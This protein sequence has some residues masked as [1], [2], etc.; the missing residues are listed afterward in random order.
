MKKIP[1]A[2]SII[3]LF[4]LILFGLF[5]IN[6][7][8]YTEDLDYQFESQASNKLS[9]ING[10]KRETIDLRLENH[11]QKM[12]LFSENIKSIDPGYTDNKFLESIENL[13]VPKL[14]LT[15]ITELEELSQFNVH[16]DLN[17]Q[18]YNQLNNLQGVISYGPGGIVLIYPYQVNDSSIDILY[19]T[20]SLE[21][22][23]NFM[24]IGNTEYNGTTYLI[25]EAG[26]VYAF[27]NSKVMKENLFD[28]LSQSLFKGSHSFH[29]FISNLSSGKSGITHYQMEN[30]DTYAYYSPTTMKGIYLL[31]TA[32]ST[33]L[34]RDSEAITAIAKRFMNTV[35]VIVFLLVIVVFLVLLV[36]TIK[37]NKNRDV[38]LLEKQRYQIALSHSKDTIWEYNI[39]K[40][41]LTKTEPYLGIFYGLPEVYDIRNT[42]VSS[43]IIHPEDKEIFLQFCDKLISKDPQ[44]QF[45]IRSK[46]QDEE[47]IWY[48]LSGTKLFDTEGKPISVIGQTTNIHEKK[49]EIELLRRKASQDTLTK[50]Y[51]R[52]TIR[53]KV[54]QCIEG[55]D[56]PYIFGLMIIDIDNFKMIN[57]TLGHLFGDAVLIDLSGKL[58]KLF[59]E[60]DLIGRI[61]GDEFVVFIHNAPSITFIE[62]KSKQ[63][64]TLLHDIH[65]GE[66][67]T[68]KL[69]GT[70]GISIYPTDGTTYNELLEKAEIALYHA[71][72]RGKDQ[73]SF[74]HSSMEYIYQK[75]LEK[76]SQET[77]EI[78]YHHEERSLIDSTIIANTIEILFDSREI[79][80]SIN[81]MLSL[82]G[83]YY[84][85]SRIDI[86]EFSESDHSVSI[87]HEWYSD[88]SQKLMDLVSQIPYSE[89]EPTFLYLQNDSGII[90]F[91]DISEK[92]ELL[93]IFSQYPSMEKTSSLFQCGIS[94]HGHYIGF[95]S[96]EFFGEPHAW[97]K[98]EVDSLSLLSK[99]IGSYLI[100]LRS[101]Q[102]ANLDTLTNAYN[103]NAFLNEVNK[104][105][106]QKNESTY[107]MFYTDIN[108]FKL[109][110]DNYGYQEGD[111]ILK[112]F[113]E[114][115]LQI[116]DTD[117]ILCRITGDKFAL[118]LSYEDLEDLTNRALKLQA[119]SKQVC[120]PSGEF[121]KLSVRAGIYQIQ[122][123]DTAIVAV[124]RANIA[125]KYAQLQRKGNFDFYN[126]EM[127][128]SLIE[129]KKIE[130]VMEDALQNGEFLVYYQPKININTKKICGSE[131][132]VRWMRPDVGLVS[133][134]SFIP[135]FEANGFIVNLDYYVLD[136]VCKR[137]RE[138]ID[139]GTSV[140][141]VSV[142]FS[143]EHF[144][145][146]ALPERLQLTIQKYQLPPELIEVEITESALASNDRYWL[147]LLNKIRNYGFGLAMDDFGSGMSS[148]NLLCDLPFKVLK[149]DKDFFHTKTTNVR[150]RIVI[151]S[152]VAMASQLNMD[153]ICEG[154]ETEEQI[155]FLQS[156]GCTMAQGYYFDKPLPGDVYE[157]KYLIVSNKSEEL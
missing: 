43:N 62:E 86:L 8:S 123:G 3:V 58:V 153:V 117:S 140:Y 51:N 116:G 64:L 7:K 2:T 134:A 6:Y 129:Q 126:D 59:Q 31:H 25:N 28:K 105:L 14:S 57:D 108:Q 18:Y 65:T 119:V 60:E 48:K 38:L 97:S 127:R 33:I 23:S 19:Q 30:V 12:K 101:L 155:K 11:M 154:V 24:A 144:K 109:I 77:D 98:N 45:E 110:N 17:D 42:V 55:L 118:F 47:Y 113:A 102:K 35:L 13:T 26:D 21:E 50:T 1:I 131:A 138:L 82:I 103:F 152:I 87:T 151:S 78:S 145:S 5:I 91:D 85:L 120:S 135:I 146:D 27:D 88:S 63:T 40:D 100:R 150:E 130:D 124:D 80:V 15:T 107:A 72:Q 112:S 71:K 104:Q 141:P 90:H 143:R 147:N 133:P 67:A 92:H 128:V 69:T 41:V 44:F 16:N 49:K 32:P 36:Y 10:T 39:E 94:D 149:I 156:I 68:A 132:L 93:Q 139:K 9:K 96:A 89:L 115:L 75:D 111:Y 121:Y 4:S 22:F 99:I 142:N 84:N 81:M 54:N 122:P 52:E 61:G 79:D 95:L 136:R 46:N 137:L 56:Q 20:Y 125:R 66:E 70:I 74:Y 148:L 29:N 106:K 157:E 34:D 76:I 53:E 83:V 73:Y 114:S 37:V